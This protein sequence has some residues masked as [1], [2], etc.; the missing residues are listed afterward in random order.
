MKTTTPLKV[1]FMERL[2][3]FTSN[4]MLHIRS[5]NLIEEMMT[6]A[7]DGD[8]IGAPQSMK[9]DR[10]VALDLA[11]YYWETRKRSSLITGHK[12]REAE[13]ARKRM[14]IVDQVTLFNQNTLKGYFEGR[15]KDRAMARIQAARQNW[16]YGR[17]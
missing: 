14:S 8:S 16:R 7:R 17:R 9:D 12:T 13:A 6:I 2:R 1:T 5:T 11:V 3:D 10:V 4:G 15:N